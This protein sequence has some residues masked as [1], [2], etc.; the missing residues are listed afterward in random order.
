MKHFFINSKTHLQESHKTYRQHFNGA[1]F[2]GYKMFIGAIASFI[3]GLFPFLFDGITAKI[4]ID[5][6]YDEL[7]EHKNEK[8]QKYI[9]MK[10]TK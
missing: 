5:I 1:F 8:Y 2:Y 7:D 4:I 6:Y 10:K 3:H 9:E